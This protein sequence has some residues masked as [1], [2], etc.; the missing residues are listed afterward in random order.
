[1]KIQFIS[2]V[3]LIVV[4]LTFV[5]CTTTQTGEQ[6]MQRLTETIIRFE[7]AWDSMDY[8]T[9]LQIYAQDA[10][11]LPEGYEMLK[12]REAIRTIFNE[13][14]VE[15]VKNKREKI[16]V[17]IVGNLAYEVANQETAWKIKDKESET[18]LNKYLHIWQK[19]P[20]GSWQLIV[21]MW[22]NRSAQNP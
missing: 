12:G 15:W 7:N 22:N 6:D 11:F 5:Q 9:V 3:V 13:S 20:D 18:Q 8:E 2:M 4:A 19:Q 21:D 16:A 1:M 10:V 14:S 17:K